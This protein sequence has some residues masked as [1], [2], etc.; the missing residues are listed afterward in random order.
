MMTTS[1]HDKVLKSARTFL[2]R[3]EGADAELLELT[4]S[5]R[6]LT[7]LLRQ[8]SRDGNLLIACIGP[9]RISGPVHW[10][11]SAL[12]I[13]LHQPSEKYPS[14]RITDPT[15]GLEVI[16]AKVELKENVKLF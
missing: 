15:C 6:S 16:C 12:E 1:F 2:S 13:G 5:H 14:Y 10:K 7:I 4:I 3:W 11:G 8:A 9:E